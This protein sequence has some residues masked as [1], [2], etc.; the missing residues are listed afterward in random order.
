MWVTESYEE[1]KS[2]D[3]SKKSEKERKNASQDG[4]TSHRK[5]CQFILENKKH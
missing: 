5:E 4:E 3:S 2:L 1:K